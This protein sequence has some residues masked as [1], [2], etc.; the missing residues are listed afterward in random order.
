MK[1]LLVL[2][3][4]L[5]VLGGGEPYDEVCPEAEAAAEHSDE[6]EDADDGGVDVEVLGD[7]A[8]YSR[9]SAVGGTAGESL[10]VVVHS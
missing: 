9:Q 4:A 5:V 10:Y 8:A 2:Q 7:T 6:E 1:K 3:G